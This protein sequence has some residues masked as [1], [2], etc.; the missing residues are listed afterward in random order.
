MPFIIEK[1]NK[2]KFPGNEP[3]KTDHYHPFYITDSAEGGFGLK[4]DVEQRKQRVFAG[5]VYDSDGYPLPTT[6]KTIM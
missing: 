2:K 4:N 1:I 6:G 3:S 5:I